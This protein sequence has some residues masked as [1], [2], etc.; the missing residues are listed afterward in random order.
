MFEIYTRPYI[1]K[2]RIHS[3]GVLKLYRK[4][5]MK[6]LEGFCCGCVMLGF[7]KVVCTM[8]CFAVRVHKPGLAAQSGFICNF[9]SFQLFADLQNDLIYKKKKEI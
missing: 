5:L 2:F 4:Y 3:G 1:V 7:P 6:H 9:S 8:R